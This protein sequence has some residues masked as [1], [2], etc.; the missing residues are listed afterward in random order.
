MSHNMKLTLLVEACFV[1]FSTLSVSFGT[2]GLGVF[3]TDGFSLG[4]EGASALGVAGF[5]LI[6]V[7]AFL[8]TFLGASCV[9]AISVILP[10]VS[11]V[12]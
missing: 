12:D 8:K 7:F 2:V 11:E 4:T 5:F 9:S 1:D 10:G 3:G 6:G